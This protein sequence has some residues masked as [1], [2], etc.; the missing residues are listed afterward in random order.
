MRFGILP[1]KIDR[2]PLTVN[3]TH[4]DS[5]GKLAFKK[6]VM[7]SENMSLE[8]VLG[9]RLLNGE[10]HR[11]INKTLK[12]IDYQGFEK[13]SNSHIAK[14]LGVGMERECFVR[15]VKILEE[16]G[17]EMTIHNV[18]EADISEFTGSPT[19]RG[20]SSQPARALG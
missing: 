3:D 19:T 8:D 7:V 4:L 17:V 18:F 2:K 13:H 10:T 12:G 6:A 9:A 11:F 20:Q 5:V 15:K 16:A 1:R 14:F